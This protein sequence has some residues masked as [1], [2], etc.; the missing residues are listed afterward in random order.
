MDMEFI[1]S[2]SLFNGI[3]RSDL[4]K[5][6]S[7][8]CIQEKKYKKG[9]I[10]YHQGSII[11]DIGL[12]LSGRVQSVNVDIMGNN[13][14]LLLM[15]PGE[16]FSLAYATLRNKPMMVDIIAIE[17]CCILHLDME[18]IFRICELPCQCHIQI[19][20]NL[21]EISAEKNIGLSQKITETSAK[22]IRGR[23]L[24]YFTREI[25]EQGTHELIIPLNRQQMAD[26]LNVERSALSKELG[27][28]KKEGMI[29]Y[30][31]NIF[32]IK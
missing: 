16:I 18:K 17:D 26:Y 2:T 29:D 28:M 15:H 7:C 10:I 20:K 32:R 24:T 1:A 3:R 12:I 23:I 30:H 9:E 14:I 22:T 27:R 25:S 11:K 21:L 5:M 31:R 19:M 8:L 13:N 6:F 4:E